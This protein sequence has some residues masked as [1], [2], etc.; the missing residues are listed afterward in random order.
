MSV[1]ILVLTLA[2][3][4]AILVVAAIIAIRRSYGRKARRAGYASI[5]DYLRAVPR[6]DE[7]KQDAVDMVVKG[8]VLCVV[9]LLIP[10]LILIG[11]FPLFYGSRKLLSASMGL[12]LIDDAD[13]PGA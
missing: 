1:K 10:P 4:A 7:E 5:G 2:I 6:S 12:G 11:V 13:R 8:F 3:A 9:G